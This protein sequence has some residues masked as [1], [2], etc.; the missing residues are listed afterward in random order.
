MALMAEFRAASEAA[1]R[2]VLAGNVPPVTTM[3]ELYGTEGDRYI[4]GGI[5]LRRVAGWEV[6]FGELQAGKGDKVR[7]VLDVD[8][9]GIGY[10]TSSQKISPISRRFC[11]GTKRE[12]VHN[13]SGR[14]TCS[15]PCIG[16]HGEL[17]RFTGFTGPGFL[18]EASGSSL[19]HCAK[20]FLNNVPLCGRDQILH[21]DLG[22]GDVA[23]KVANNELRALNTIA[24]ASLSTR[25]HPAPRVHTRSA[26][27]NL[28]VFISARIHSES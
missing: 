26:T 15:A 6:C 12:S 8:D 16:R 17:R 28:G 1:V 10:Q 27:V 5:L 14:E 22:E 19:N 25:P 21:E 9:Q 20:R 11:G 24:R 23:F 13:L 4:V 3:P 18:K 2:L 7:A